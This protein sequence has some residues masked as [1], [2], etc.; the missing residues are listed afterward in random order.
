MRRTKASPWK[1]SA[2]FLYAERDGE[3]AE[4]GFSFGN[5]KILLA[6]PKTL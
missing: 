2:S 5:Y 4:T 3:F 1:R 6:F